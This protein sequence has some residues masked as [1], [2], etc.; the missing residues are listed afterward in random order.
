[1]AAQDSEDAVG[2][3]VDIVDLVADQEDTDAEAVLVE[4]LGKVRRRG[5]AD[6]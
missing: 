4:A 1:M 5:G 2:R 3:V 6:E